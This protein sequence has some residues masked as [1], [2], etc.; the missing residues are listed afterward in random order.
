MGRDLCYFKDAQ[1]NLSKWA[2]IF[3]IFHSVVL[4][5]P[6]KVSVL[7]KKI[8]D[9]MVKYRASAWLPLH[10]QLFLQASACGTFL[11]KIK[12]W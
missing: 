6:Y 5:A 8:I 7:C 2:G 11:E 1:Q 10:F 9:F 12:I 3:P 4:L